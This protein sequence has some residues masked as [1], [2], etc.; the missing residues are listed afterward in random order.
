M[1]LRAEGPWGK[2]S[3]KGKLNTEQHKKYK[4]QTWP[5]F[6]SPSRGET[7]PRPS[8]GG[9]RGRVGSTCTPNP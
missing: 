4:D 8:L 5:V 7:S 6:A 1:Y 9:H 3:R 2:W